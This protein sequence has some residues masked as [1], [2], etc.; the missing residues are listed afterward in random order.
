MENIVLAETATAD[1]ALAGTTMALPTAAV[2]AGSVVGPPRLPPPRSRPLPVGVDSSDVLS[3]LT[4]AEAAEWYRR[5]ALAIG[6]KKSDS[7]AAELLLRWLAGKGES[8][9]FSADHV[10]S[11]SY[12]TDALR[13]TVRG[14]L[15]TDKKRPNGTWAGV[16]TRLKAEPTLPAD[17][18]YSLSFEAAVSIPETVLA[19]PFV[20]YLAGLDVEI[21][22]ELDIFAALHN[23]GLHTDVVTH[24]VRIANSSKYNVTFTSWVTHAFDRYHFDPNKWLIVPNPDFG[25]P[26]GVAPD[27]RSVK[28]YHR[29]A[30]RVENAGY[31]T[32]FDDQSTEWSPSDPDIVGPGEV[33]TARQLS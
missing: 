33:D 30:I 32:Q 20:A 12:V 29:N 25:N 2:D 4:A 10:Q 11:L 22:P 5:L 16:L 21:T 18:S 3:V 31:A 1:V 19:G 15:L 27:K 9:T 23:F 24:A 13:G 28:A 6:S 14:V 17:K 26:D 7:L 8:Y